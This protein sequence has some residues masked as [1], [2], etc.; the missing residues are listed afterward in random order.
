MAATS[1]H[2]TELRKTIGEK[3][4]GATSIPGWSSLGWNSVPASSNP[5]FVPEKLR[6]G[7]FAGRPAYAYYAL[8][9]NNQARVLC[10]F[11]DRDG[12]L[13]SEISNALF[14]NIDFDEPFKS[15]EASHLN[16][17]ER[18]G[19]LRTVLR[20]CFILRGHPSNHTGEMSMSFKE[21]FRRG[22]AI[23]MK[24][25]GTATP[26]I[27]SNEFSPS[28]HHEKHHESA[29]TAQNSTNGK[30]DTVHVPI[31]RSLQCD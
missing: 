31:P 16:T 1:T 12:D 27:P 4:D 21:Y 7:T 2:I 24:A 19:I 25:Q 17:T 5:I 28:K 14:G 8:S 11:R 22:L 6:V 26:A 30:A 18:R 15:I 13:P 23:I 20:A 10:I 9:S 29:S 3:C